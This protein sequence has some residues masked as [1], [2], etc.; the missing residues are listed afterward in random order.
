MV[1]NAVRGRKFQDRLMSSLQAEHWLDANQGVHGQPG[2]DQA[3][4]YFNPEPGLE[5]A[6]AS[7]YKP[8]W[9]KM[10]PA[11]AKHSQ[12]ILPLGLSEL[13][14]DNQRNPRKRS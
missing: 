1:L 5:H 4:G 8:S 2:P 9:E 3:N 7:I 13:N 12:G 10:T 14:L 11:S 6:L